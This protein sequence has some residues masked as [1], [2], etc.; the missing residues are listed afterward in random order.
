[1][2]KMQH[3][4]NCGTEIGVYQHFPGDLESC[5]KLECEREARYQMQIA[6][7]EARER[8]EVDDYGLYR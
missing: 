8:A 4:F 7:F 3:C 6:E 2:E 5:G 1:M